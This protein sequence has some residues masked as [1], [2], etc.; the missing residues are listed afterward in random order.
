MSKPKG[1]PK[2]VFDNYP[3]VISTHG[4]WT[5][6]ACTKTWRTCPGCQVVRFP[7]DSKRKK[8]WLESLELNKKV[9]SKDSKHVTNWECDE[10]TVVCILHFD[11]TKALDF[12][13]PTLCYQDLKEKDKGEEPSTNEIQNDIQ[14]MQDCD[15]IQDTPHEIENTQHEIQDDIFISTAEE[16]IEFL[17]ALTIEN[18]IL[19]NN[20]ADL[21]SENLSLRRRGTKLKLESFRT[22]KELR[23]CLGVANKQVFLY[24]L[25]KI[26]MILDTKR[27]TYYGD[28][29]GS[30]IHRIYDR[31][32]K[33]RCL[34]REEEFIII[35]LILRQ[36]M[37]QSVLATIFMVSQ[38]TIS[39]I[40]NTWI[41]IL[42]SDI[43]YNSLVLTVEGEENITYDGQTTSK[44]IDCFELEAETPDSMDVA[45]AFWSSY[46]HKYGVKF[47]IASTPSGAICYLSPAYGA[48][49][50]DKQITTDSGFLDILQPNEVILCDRGFNVDSLLINRGCKIAIPPRAQG[51]NQFTEAEIKKTKRVANERILIENVIGRLRIFQILNGKLEWRYTEKINEIV[52]CCAILCNLLPPAHQRDDKRQSEAI[53]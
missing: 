32:N 46:K 28:V 50:S 16:A 23:I 34:S 2:K 37:R 44:I 27:T 3:N 30:D 20:I 48:R 1:R 10:N 6:V 17:R 4:H 51:V 41:D 8:S 15:E 39:R 24:L 45:P 5:C 9:I 22:D 42:S 19:K 40:F 33:K 13:I 25:D 49:A 47:L 29:Y 52:K 14:N 38:P 35:L 21:Q 53:E 26:T 7:K 31:T 43:F 12:Q 11:K 18:D 36:N